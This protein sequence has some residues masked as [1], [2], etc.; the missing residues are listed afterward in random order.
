MGTVVAIKAVA[1]EVVAAGAELVVIESMKMEHPVVA[2]FSCRISVIR[3]EIGQ[4]VNEGDVL[5]EVSREGSA[6]ANVV[7]PSSAKQERSDLAKLLKR[8]AMLEDDARS[9]AVAK[10]HAKGQRRSHR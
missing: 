7:T 1:G 5:L 9:E 8:Q 2:D 6:S 4:T 10:R 3:V